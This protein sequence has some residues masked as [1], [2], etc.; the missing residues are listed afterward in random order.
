MLEG[1]VTVILSAITAALGFMIVRW[2]SSVDQ[3]LH[4]LEEANKNFSEE[5]NKLQNEFIS[6]EEFI[7]EIKDVH[8][9]N[10]SYGYRIDRIDTRLH[11]VEKQHNVLSRLISTSVKNMVHK[12]D[13]N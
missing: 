5:L 12:N 7:N 1:I 3:K 11:T 4:D 2:L 6:K 13:K 8:R 10:E 9:T